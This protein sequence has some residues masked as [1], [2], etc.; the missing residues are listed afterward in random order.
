MEIKHGLI[1]CDS[2][3]QMDKENWTRRMSKAKWGDR[4]PHLIETTDKAYIIEEIVARGPAGTKDRPVERWQVNG[5]IVGDR[6]PANCPTVMGDPM[7]KYYPQRWEEVPA[8]V[9]DPVER[10]KAQDEDG[11]DAEILFPNDPVQGGTFFQGGDAEFELA[12]IQ[13][14]N[15]GLTEWQEVSDRYIPLALIPYLGGIESTVGEVERVAKNGHRGIVM[16]AEPSYSLK[17][18]KH[19]NDPYWDPLWATCQDLDLVVH[20]HGAGGL[21]LGMP[22]WEGYTRW[23]TQAMGVASGH[24]TLAQYLSNVMFSGVLDRY[25]RLQWVCAETGLGWVNYILEGCD[26]EWERRHLWTEGMPLRPSDLFRRQMYVDFWYE[27]AGVEMRHQIGMNNIMW[28]SDFPH[29]TATYP[30][31]WKFVERSLKGVPQEEREQLLYG[32][33][34]RLYK[35]T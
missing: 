35:L 17:G 14:Y 19:F 18:L 3:A 21:R 32:N 24:G 2:H 34:V 20:W 9:Y 12:C 6:G 23:E 15:D 1:S 11:I 7:R 13:A 27:E 26:H 10:L 33:A 25:P 22:R 16:L 8:K 28:E 5:E 29:S 31:S 4:I 30:E